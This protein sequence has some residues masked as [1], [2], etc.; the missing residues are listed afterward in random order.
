MYHLALGQIPLIL[1]AGVLSYQW[2]ILPGRSSRERMLGGFALGITLA[3]P[4]LLIWLY[5]YAVW[6]ATAKRQFETL[7]G[8]VLGTAFI[9]IPPFLFNSSIYKF[10]IEYFSFDQTQVWATPT[11]SSFLILYMHLGPTISKLLPMLLG[12]LLLV[13]LFLR[14]EEL[15]HQPVLAANL[16]LLISLVFAPYLWVYDLV[17]VLPAALLAIVCSVAQREE[18]SA[19]GFLSLPT[20]ILVVSNLLFLFQKRSYLDYWYLLIYFCVFLYVFRKEVFQSKRKSS[21]RDNMTSDSAYP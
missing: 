6:Y 3:K 2:S 21:A 5:M 1:F 13:I 9:S 17:L 10:F 11:M 7:V 20:V 8:G 16:C 15:R 14:S 4:H 18:E 12:G 19:G